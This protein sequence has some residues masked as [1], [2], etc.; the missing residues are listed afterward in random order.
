M[1]ACFCQHVDQAVLKSIPSRRR[2]PTPRPGRIHANQAAKRE[3]ATSGA[4]RTWCECIRFICFQ[5]MQDPNRQESR[6]ASNSRSAQ[7]TNT[8]TVQ[9]LLRAS[10]GGLAHPVTCPP[11]PH[12]MIDMEKSCLRTATSQEACK[13]THLPFIEFV[14]LQTPMASATAAHQ[15][16]RQLCR[17]RGTPSHTTPACTQAL[18]A[19]LCHAQAVG[20]QSRPTWQV[21]V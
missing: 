7:L 18:N 12:T 17:D 9:P 3:T 15:T 14:P 11:C 4:H 16:I 19:G 6:P 13:K 21:L 2:R 10:P 8:N 1:H 5:C 20:C